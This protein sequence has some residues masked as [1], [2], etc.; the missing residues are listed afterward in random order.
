[1]SEFVHP[2]SGEILESREEFDAAI[3][4]L[5]IELGL[6]YRALW[7]LREAVAERYPAAE[8][9]AP[10]YRTSTQEKVARCPRCGGKV[11]GPELGT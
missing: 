7:P 10:R 2:T 1:M 9:P 8:Q 5:E 3:A 4:A 6:V 11:E